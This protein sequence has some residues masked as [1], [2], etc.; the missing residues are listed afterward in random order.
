M[1]LFDS[2]EKKMR[3]AGMGDA[4]IAVFKRNYEALLRDESGMISED[5]I[6]PAQGLAKSQELNASDA[7]SHLGEVVV[8]KLNGGLGTGMGLQGPKS[9]LDV[10]NGVNFLD[11]MVRQISSL[12]EASG[13]NVR[14]LLMNSFS[15]SEDTLAHLQRYAKQGFAD[16]REVEM[17]QNMV[18]K[19][20]A[21]TLQPA[22]WPSDPEQ[23]W[24]PPGHGD[25]YP[26][27]V[28]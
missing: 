14:L 8:V 15:T 17:M 27:L 10:R 18:P 11:L 6:V 22:E 28:G 23:E 21:T 25:L 26:A 3:S 19:I 7:V 4:P 1:D 5:S 2:F 16:A 9:L 12:R 24:C 13:S 20:D